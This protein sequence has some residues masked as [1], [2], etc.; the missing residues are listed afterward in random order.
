M[1]LSLFLNVLGD[2]EERT[3]YRRN[4]K[5]IIFCIHLNLRF[6]P[7]CSRLSWMVC[8][9]RMIFIRF[10]EDVFPFIRFDIIEREKENCGGLFK[11]G[12]VRLNRPLCAILI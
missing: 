4:R 12:V 10:V 3:Y 11:Y 6:S 1:R 9:G 2:V 5:N 7:F 8:S